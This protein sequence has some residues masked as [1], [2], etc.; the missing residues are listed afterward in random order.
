MSKFV[1]PEVR[2]DHSFVENK[3]G[4]DVAD[5]YRWLE[6]VDSPETAEFV[7][8]QNALTIPYIDSCPHK[9]DIKKRSVVFLFSLNRH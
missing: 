5:P 2:R 1:Y 9:A 3:F 6:D 4:V 8:K 7:A